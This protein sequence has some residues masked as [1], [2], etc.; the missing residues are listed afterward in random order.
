MRLLSPGRSAGA[1]GPR[2][3]K[4]TVCGAEDPIWR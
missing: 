4:A 2:I 1:I 3:A